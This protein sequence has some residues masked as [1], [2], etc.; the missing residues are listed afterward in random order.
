MDPHDG[1]MGNVE[2]VEV[3]NTQNDLERWEQKPRLLTYNSHVWFC[4]ELRYTRVHQNLC[5][6]YLCE[7]LGKPLLLSEQ[8]K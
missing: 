4:L 7:V 1:P 5:G 2:T 8:R 3:R 6:Q